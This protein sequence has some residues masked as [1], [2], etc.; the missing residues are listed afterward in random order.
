MMEIHN[1]EVLSILVLNS[2]VA[3]KTEN[4]LPTGTAGLISMSYYKIRLDPRL[5]LH[6]VHGLFW[7]GMFIENDTVQNSSVNSSVR[8]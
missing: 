8:L 6:H 7:P 4:V 1:Y 2:L 3:T 5:D